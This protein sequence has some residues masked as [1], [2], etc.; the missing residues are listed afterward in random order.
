MLLDKLNSYKDAYKSWLASDAYDMYYLWETIATFQAN[1]DV[2]DLDFKSMFERSFSNTLT[3]DLWE[4]RDYFPKRAMLQMIDRD[5]DLVRSMFKELYDE[6]LDITG[7]VDRFLYHCDAMR[8]DI[9]RSS[10]EYQK[11]YHGDYRMISTYLALKFPTKY[12]VYDF[13]K[14]RRYMEAVGAKPIP[15]GHDLERFFK[16]MRTTYKILE[17]D[18]ELLELHR[19]V[20]AERPDIWQGDC[21]GLAMEFYSHC[22]KDA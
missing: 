22:V 6:S 17:R 3:N 13:E 9:L 18:Q 7:R 21:L 4:G 19:K 8:D 1:W 10:K 14:W 11:H 12:A 15:E 16:V 5:D 2:A 20:R